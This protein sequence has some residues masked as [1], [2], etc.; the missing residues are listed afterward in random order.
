MT[1]K[2]TKKKNKKKTSKKNL[3]TIVK[4][5]KKDKLKKNW[6]KKKKTKKNQKIL[7][8]KSQKFLDDFFF[9]TFSPKLFCFLIV[10]HLFL[11]KIT[12]AFLLGTIQC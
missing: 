8:S 9:S 12:T 11:K 5:G 10:Y 6:K 7:K 2:N 1:K 3:G 4:V